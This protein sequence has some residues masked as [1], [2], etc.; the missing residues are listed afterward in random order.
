MRFLSLQ[1]DVKVVCTVLFPITL[2]TDI[3]RAKKSTKEL[4]L[5]T[6]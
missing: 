5:H 6:L 4:V 1:G 2:E 3:R